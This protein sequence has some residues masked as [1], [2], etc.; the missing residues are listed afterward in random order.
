MFKFD[1]FIDIKIK[2]FCRF[3]YVV[4][5]QTLTRQHGMFAHKKIINCM[6]WHPQTVASDNN[7]SPYKDWL[8]TA[9]EDIKVYDV[10]SGKFV[11]TVC[12]TKIF[13]F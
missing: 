7:I 13:T 1:F 11:Y 12:F 5:C 4:E 8:A 9:S 3:V 10:S 2:L 6:E